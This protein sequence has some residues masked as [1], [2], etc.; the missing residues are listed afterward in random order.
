MSQDEL[1]RE[2][3]L[4]RE[5]L[6]RE[7]Q[8][9]REVATHESLLAKDREW[10]I[11]SF[12]SIIDFAQSS[13]RTTLLLN[14]GALIALLALVGNL[15]SKN[16]TREAVIQLSAHVFPAMQWFVGG[17]VCGA[18]V[19][20]GS[21]LAQTFFQHSF[22]AAWRG[23]SFER[24]EHIGLVFQ[25][26]SITL[27]I[28]SVAAF[29]V[30]SYKAATSLSYSIHHASNSKTPISLKLDCRFSDTPDLKC[31]IQIQD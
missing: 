24:L 5:E 4:K 3:Q 27:C 13:I 16:I 7:Y 17:L 25:V 20:M 28:G 12:K 14:G 15:Y 23:K 22:D 30:G 29:A 26:I 9:K 10:V 11:A 18:C 21:Y 8:L 6:E 1:K 2:Y 31:E 19:A